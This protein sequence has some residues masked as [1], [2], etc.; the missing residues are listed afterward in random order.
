MFVHAFMLGES[1]DDLQKPLSL[2]RN[3][4][5]QHWTDNQQKKT[6]MMTTGKCQPSDGMSV[7]G[8]TIER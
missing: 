3:G 8:K 4:S 7:G 1:C 2:G 6:K 5:R